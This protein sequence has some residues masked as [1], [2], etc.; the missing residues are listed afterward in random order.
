MS[1]CSLNGRKDKISAPTLLRCTASSQELLQLLAMEMEIFCRTFRPSRIIPP[2]MEI[3][4]RIVRTSRSISSDRFCKSPCQ[5][6]NVIRRTRILPTCLT[7]I[8][9]VD[10][11]RHITKP[12]MAQA[13]FR[14]A[15]PFRV[16]L[17]H[18]HQK[19]SERIRFRS[20]QAV[21]FSQHV[22]EGPK[23]HVPD[24]KQL[25]TLV[26][27]VTRVLA[28]IKKSARDGSEQLLHQREMVLVTI[29]IATR[30]RIEQKITRCNLEHYA[31]KTPNIRRAI[32]SRAENNLGTSVLPCLNV[33][34]E[35]LVSP[36]RI[37]KVN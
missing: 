20:R 19:T 35:M 11:L 16:K 30:V 7:C 33:F 3:F 31:R 18:R 32:I 25:A 29:I 5:V 4:R 17:Q 10:Q 26:E 27:K 2:E 28:T 36:A 15:P 1:M 13:C 24:V 21:L 6:L 14:R 12:R 22:R 34:S 8:H 23:V 37:P 9:R